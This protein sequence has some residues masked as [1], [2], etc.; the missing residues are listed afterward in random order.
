MY[1]DL[2][3]IPVIDYTISSF[4]VMMALGFL[5]AYWLT[6]KRMAELDLDPEL[7][8]TILI[9][10]MIGGVLGSKL[11]YTIDVGLRTGA[12]WS[13]L[14]FARAGITWYGGLMGGILAGFIGSKMNGVTFKT[15][16]DCGAAGT[17]LG[18]SLGRVGCFLVGDDY[19]Q[20]TDAWY[21]IAFP[22]G[23]PPILDTVHATQLYEVAWLVPVAGLLWMRRSRS[24]F[25]F[26][27]YMALNGLGRIAIEH[28]RVNPEMALGLT[29]P[30]WIGISLM[31]S[32]MGFWF[33]Y[34]RRSV[35]STG[36]S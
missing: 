36:A 28:L 31:V 29:Q 18:Q 9:Y 33:Y 25:L 1:P 12:P 3:T 7:A 13:D 16:L 21:G 6:A 17:A 23:A 22:N 20:P 24:P 14:F 11:Y 10:C 32:G 35:E 34:W 19:G 15:V 27:E 5:A 8:A 30:Q 26:G 4:G 2:F